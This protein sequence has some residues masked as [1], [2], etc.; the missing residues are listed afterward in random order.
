V[1]DDEETLGRLRS[2]HCPDCLKPGL[3][4]GPRGGAGQNL[5]CDDCGA[6]FNV[7]LPRYIVFAQ[8]IEDSR[9]V[10]GEPSKE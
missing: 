7:A 10:P 8:R 2:D 3:R 6:K 9:F 4:A 5:I 1:I